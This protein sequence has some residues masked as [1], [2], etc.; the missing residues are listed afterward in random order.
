MFTRRAA[1]LLDEIELKPISAAGALFLIFSFFPCDSNSNRTFSDVSRN[2][3]RVALEYH[4]L[5]IR[6][7]FDRCIQRIKNSLQV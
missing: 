4:T 2:E 3:K 6:L 5:P 7:T 1:D